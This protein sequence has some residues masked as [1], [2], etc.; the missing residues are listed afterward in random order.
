MKKIKLLTV[1]ALTLVI[2]SCSS[3]DE[4]SL[5]ESLIEN[6]D[7]GLSAKSGKNN[8]K[9][10]FISVAHPT[11]GK[12]IVNK[13]ITKLRLVNFKTDNGPSLEIYLATDSNAT[14]Y[15]SLGALEEKDLE[16]NSVY[17]IP[18]GVNIAKYNHVIIWC[19]AFSV[20]FGYAVVN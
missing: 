19:S 10:K 9:G 4:N 17:S 1:L 13:A 6:T 18:E 11:S 12:A 20:N 7:R 2:S 14:E 8:F 16:G 5:E 15:I 3:N